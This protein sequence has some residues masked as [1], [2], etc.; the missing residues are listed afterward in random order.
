MAE[1]DLSTMRHSAAH[2]MAAALQKLYPTVKLD[3]GPS[4][5]EGFYYDFDIPGKRLTPEDLKDIEKEMKKML[6]RQLPFVRKEVSREEARE[7]F[8]SRGQDFKLS[9][10]DDIPEGETVSL[11]YTGDE[12]GAAAR[13]WSTAVRLARSSCC[14]WPA[15]TSAA[16]RRTR[17]CSASTARRSRRRRS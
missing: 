16:T 17:C 10:L 13:T 5:E 3:I 1:F 14:R 8:A 11:Y 6:G 15:R 12:Y 2:I 4:T 7:L 9:R